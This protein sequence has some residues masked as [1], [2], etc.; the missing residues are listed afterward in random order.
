[1][2]TCYRTS[3]GTAERPFFGVTMTTEAEPRRD[4]VTAADPEELHDLVV[5]HGDAIYRLAFSIVGDRALAEDIAQ[6]A[7]VKAWL[8][9]PSLR[10]RSAL[11]SWILR[12]THNTSISMLRTRRAVVTDPH[13]LPEPV[14]AA[15]KSVESQVQ[16]EAVVSDFIAALST[17]DDLSRSI[18][19]LRELEGFSY[20]EIAEVLAVPLPTVKTRLFRA[21]RRLGTNLREWT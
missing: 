19:V 10:S 16:S 20:D 11:R 6:E 1:M 4:K 2:S 18:V 9:L 3:P 17:L 7:L 21:R 8:A 15:E 12:I 13:G 5:E 14:I